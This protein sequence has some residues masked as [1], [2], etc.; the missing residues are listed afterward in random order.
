MAGL[1]VSLPP[2]TEERLKELEQGRLALEAE[3]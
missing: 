3:A 1:E 2:Q